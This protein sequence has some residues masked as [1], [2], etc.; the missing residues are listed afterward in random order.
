MK[1][2]FKVEYKDPKDNEDKVTGI[3]LNEEEAFSWAAG[4]DRYLKIYDTDL[5]GDIMG[6]QIKKVVVVNTADNFDKEKEVTID[7]GAIIDWKLTE[8]RQKLGGVE[9]PPEVYVTF[10]MTPLEFAKILESTND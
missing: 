7:Y 3:F 4:P 10:S 2:Y 1:I 8:A 9:F 6:Y 5:E